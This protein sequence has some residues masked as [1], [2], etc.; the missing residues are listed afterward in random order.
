VVA[1]ELDGRAAW[2]VGTAT[3]GGRL[4]VAADGSGELLRATITGTG[5]VDLVFD[6]WGRA[7][8]WHAPAATERP[9][10]P[11]PS[12]VPAPPTAVG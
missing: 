5:A 7:T 8:S 11:S 12:V 6:R 2:V 9:V 4:W 1:T 10:V 3:T